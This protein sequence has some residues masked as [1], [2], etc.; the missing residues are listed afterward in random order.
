MFFAE[1]TQLF[2]PVIQRNPRMQVVRLGLLAAGVGECG[3]L[4]A[5]AVHVS[6]GCPFAGP[7]SD[8][9]PSGPVSIGA[10]VVQPTGCFLGLYVDV[11]VILIV[12]LWNTPG[13]EAFSCRERGTK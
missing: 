8:T 10:A 12:E 11:V 5:Y 13:N 7:L 4:C 2:V 3:R 9:A 1:S 6:R